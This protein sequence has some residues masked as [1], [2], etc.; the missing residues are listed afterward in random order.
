MWAVLSTP[1]PSTV[2]VFLIQTLP[3]KNT[4]VLTD[5]IHRHY[6]QYS[7]GH[8]APCNGKRCTTVPRSL[9]RDLM[10]FYSDILAAYKLTPF[11]ILSGPNVLLITTIN[12]VQS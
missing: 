7:R 12:S 8:R 11:P 10:V 2:A 3:P 9:D 5:H 6:V 4:Q 1:A